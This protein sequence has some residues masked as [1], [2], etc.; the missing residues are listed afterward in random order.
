MQCSANGS[1]G[2]PVRTR[3]SSSSAIPWRA[4]RTAAVQAAFVPCAVN[5]N[6][7]GGGMSLALAGDIVMAAESARFTMAYT[8]VGLTPDGSSTHTLPCCC[9]SPSGTARVISGMLGMT[10]SFSAES[11]LYP[12]NADCKSASRRRPLC[13]RA[14]SPAS[15]S[16]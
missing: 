3:C 1:G 9:N 10:H 4:A 2:K 8:R 11:V 7:G 6:A 5:G 16:L 14:S 13:S 15:P 12:A